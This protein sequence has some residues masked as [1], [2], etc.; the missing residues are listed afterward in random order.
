MKAG[1]EMPEE[2][3]DFERFVPRDFFHGFDIITRTVKRT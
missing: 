2:E 3:R 1:W